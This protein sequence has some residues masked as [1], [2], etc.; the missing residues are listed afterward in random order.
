MQEAT[1]AYQHWM[2]AQKAAQS[3]DMFDDTLDAINRIN[4]TLSNKDS[5]YFGRVG[6]TDYKAAVDLIVPESIDSEN[7]GK[8]KAYLKSIKDLFTY[9]DDGNRA[10]LNIENFCKRAVSKG[11]MVLDKSSGEYKI[12]G[13]KTMQDF[14]DGLNLSLPMVQAM[15]GEMEEF[16][17]EFSFLDEAAKTIGDLGVSANEAAEK[18]RGLTGNEDLAIRLD[19]SALDTT[20]DKIA[21]LETTITEMQTLKGKANVDSSEIE[22]ANQIIEY[23]VAQEQNL[24]EPIVM[25]VNTSALD[26]KT[27]DAINKIQEFKRACNDLELRQKLG[28]DTTEAEKQVNDLAGQVKGIDSNILAS[29]SLD[30]SSVDTLKASVNAITGEQ[31]NVKLGIDESAI[32][33]W[34]ADSKSATVK[35]G[36]DSSEV[37]AYK[38]QSEDKTATVTFHKVSTEVDQY[39]PLNLSR[40]VTYHVKTEGSV[41]ANGTAHF[42][43]TAK[44]GGDWGTAKGGTTLVGELGTEIVCIPKTGKWYTVGE[45]GAEFRDIPQGAI[46]FNHKQTESLLKYGHIASR[47]SALVGG[48]ALASG[49]A[50][51]TGGIK[52]S[53]ANASTTT[54]RKTKTKTKTKSKTKSKSKSSS[55]STDLDT[56]DWIEI[57]ISRL[58]KAVDAFELTAN[59][60]YETLQA[61]LKATSGEISTITK[62]ISVQEQAYK[63]YIKQA[64]SVG[65]SSALKKKVQ[66]GTI[67]ISKYDEKTQKLISD[68]KKWYETL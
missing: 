57:A 36:V 52:V 10:G 67:D 40:T 19:V 15:F 43:G 27:A 64:D 12:A 23:C 56:I 38:Q 11:L 65:L 1:S 4:D 32:I 41:S 7:E 35:Y 68:Y 20:E 45:D 13:Q 25:A 2:N 28:V 60:T 47:A 18:L 42:E 39:N 17:G 53:S 55:K 24:S 58:E 5:E 22:Y 26:E 61:R 33:G 48:T 21:A 30:T 49:T 3:G 59:S 63:R 51:V 46:V 62:E 31:L 50:M 8:V 44:A 9:D 29:L 66:D 16:G 6:R 14:A 34:Q 37:D 54:R